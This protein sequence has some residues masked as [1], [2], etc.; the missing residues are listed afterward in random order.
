MP[1][2]VVYLAVVLKETFSFQN[3]VLSSTPRVEEFVWFDEAENFH[4]RFYSKQLQVPQSLQKTPYDPLLEE[5]VWFDFQENCDKPK[6]TATQD[7]TQN[8][9]PDVL[10]KYKEELSYPWQN[11]DEV[12]AN[13]FFSNKWK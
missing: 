7:V 12:F 5:M 13:Y 11:E 1:Y 3:Q 10:E 4:H 8:K 9:T 2:L 6:H